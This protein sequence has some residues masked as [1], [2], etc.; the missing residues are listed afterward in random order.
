M[1]LTFLG[2]T[3]TVTGSKYLLKSG[4]A[5]TLVDCG[6]LQGLKAPR[7]RNWAPLPLSP[8]EVDAVVTQGCDPARGLRNQVRCSQRDRRGEDA[9]EAAGRR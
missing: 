7:L 8:K 4:G 3:G 2:G 9:E 6:L 1:E 5:T